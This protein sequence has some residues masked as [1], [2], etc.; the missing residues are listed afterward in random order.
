M[1]KINVLWMTAALLLGLAACG[2]LPEEGEVD[3]FEVVE[4]AAEVDQECIRREIQEVAAGQTFAAPTDE[5]IRVEIQS[6]AAPPCPPSGPDV[7]YFSHDPGRCNGRL[8][9]RGE[10]D[11]SMGGSFFNLPACGCGCIYSDDGMQ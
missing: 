3:E 4:A 10:C 7:V 6:D 2:P 1:N 9:I 5:G 11:A 8:A